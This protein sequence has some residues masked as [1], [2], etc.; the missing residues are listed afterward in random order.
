MNPA[1]DPCPPDLALALERE[2]FRCCRQSEPTGDD[3]LTAAESG[4]YPQ[5]DPC[6]RKSLSVFETQHD[7]EHQVRLF[8]KWPRKFIVRAE[9][10]ARHGRGMRTRGQQ[11][12]HTS[13]WPAADLSPDL[14]A[15]LFEVV[16]E[17]ES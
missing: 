3:M 1:S 6:L 10:R 16:A 13:W 11:P 4:R 5:N 9:L 15:L 8:K 12:T 14:R 7:A 2:V 17:V